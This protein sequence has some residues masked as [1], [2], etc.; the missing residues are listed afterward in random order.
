MYIYNTNKELLRNLYMH[1]PNIF[2]Y[3]VKILEPGDIIQ[4]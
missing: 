4:S 1:F 2:L 3:D